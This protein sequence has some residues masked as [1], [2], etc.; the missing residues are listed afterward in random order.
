MPGSFAFLRLFS[1]VRLQG[2]DIEEIEAL[3]AEIISSW[4]KNEDFENGIIAYT[5]ESHN[6]FS[7]LARKEKDISSIWY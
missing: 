3:A 4:E 6:G 2:G 7:V 5:N 1:I